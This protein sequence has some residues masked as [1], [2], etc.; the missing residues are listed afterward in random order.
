MEGSE[1]VGEFRGESVVEEDRD[2]S[3]FRGFRRSES[4]VG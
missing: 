3:W 1:G 4:A 2:E